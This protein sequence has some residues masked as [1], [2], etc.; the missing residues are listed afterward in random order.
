MSETATLNKQ[1]I[2]V[3]KKYPF[4]FNKRERDYKNTVKKS[5]TCEKIAVKLHL[6]GVQTWEIFENLS[7]LRN[8]IEHNKRTVTNYTP[9]KVSLAQ[10]SDETS[11]AESTSSNPSICVE[12]EQSS[13][14]EYSTL[15]CTGNTDCTPS[16]KVPKRKALEDINTHFM[17]AATSF[18][19]ICST[20]TNRKQQP[21]EDELFGRGRGSLYKCQKFQNH[22]SFSEFCTVFAV[23]L[24]SN[25]MKS[26]LIISV[27]MAVAIAKPSLPHLH[28]ASYSSPIHETV[29]AGPSVVH[30]SYSHHDALHHPIQ[31]TFIAEAPGVVHQS[32]VQPAFHQAP[33]V[34]H[35][36]I[37]H[38]AP[39]VLHHGVAPAV[40]HHKSIEAHVPTAVS[41]QHSTVVH[42]SAHSNVHHAISHN[43]I[44]S[45]PLIHHAV[46]VAH[47]AI[48]A[49]VVAP[50]SS[51]YHAQD[52][53]GQ[54]SFGYSSPLSSKAEVKTLDG[55]TKGGFNYLDAFGNEQS[56]SYVSDDLH[57]FRVAA[58][59]LPIGPEPVV[60]TSEVVA[61]KSAHLSA[62]EKTKASLDAAHASETAHK[63][64]AIAPSSDSHQA[65][66]V[67]LAPG[68]DTPEVAAAKAAHLSIHAKTKAEIDAVNAADAVYQIAHH[69]VAGI[70]PYSYSHLAA[71]VVLAPGVDTPAVAAAKAAHLSIHAKTKAELDAVN[72]A[73]AVYQVAH[74]EVAGIAPYSYSHL[75]AP[76]VL[77]PGVDTPAVA[78]AKAAH[79]SIHAKTKA[80]L[81]AVNAADAVYQV[82][83]HEVAGIAPY[84]Y[85]HLAAPVILAPG[86]DTPAVAAAKVAHLSIHAN[87]KAQLDAV[88]GA[89]A[90]HQVFHHEI[91]GIAPVIPV[92]PSPYSYS[93]LAHQPAAFI[94][95]TPGLVLTSAGVP[96]ETAEVA[97]AKAVHFAAH[98]S[99]Y[100][101]DEKPCD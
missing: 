22:Y 2:E 56:V 87:T 35:H 60:D 18:R 70:A 27:V 33:A 77:A 17:E 6:T 9:N 19:E 88:N 50:V 61:A 3:V 29:I 82:A 86:V 43:A 76:V 41:E 47:H 84:S 36:G 38:V 20:V 92:A 30:H 34:V 99:A 85:S 14:V 51:Q 26:F 66:P 54:Y 25:K 100:A 21:T 83:H 37:S 48:V 96:L 13:L 31:E 67:V 65:A 53:L 69:E 42:N 7:F 15:S 8:H 24:T 75:T 98:H 74:H 90:A 97:K 63:D 55:V 93:Y 4:L 64:A 5:R 57:G 81:D 62:Y 89:D 40:F 39:A 16:R 73:D 44:V 58:S 10:T 52:A 72:A 49:D 91:G 71:P 46:P 101:K 59:N 80:E 78:A 11:C 12:E 1:L 94:H 32:V 68:E 23:A 28:P 79:L 45:E 95:D